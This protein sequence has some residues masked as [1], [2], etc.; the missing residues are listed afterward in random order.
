VIKHGKGLLEGDIMAAAAQ[1]D[2]HGAFVENFIEP[3]PEFVKNL[4][5]DADDRT[6]QFFVN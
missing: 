2:H 1:L 5:R 6:A 4:H 3:W